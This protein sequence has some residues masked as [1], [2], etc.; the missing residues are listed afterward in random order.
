LTLLR[1]CTPA[2]TDCNGQKRSGSVS[3]KYVLPAT[4]RDDVLLFSSSPLSL[5]AGQG[6]LA[7]DA[8]PPACVAKGAGLTVARIS[9]PTSGTAAVRTPCN[10]MTCCTMYTV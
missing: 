7:N 8:N 9:A 6:L 5:A 4:A 2:P 1:V 3:L 10:C